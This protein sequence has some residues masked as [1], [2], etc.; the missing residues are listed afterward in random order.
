MR[1]AV[2]FRD[3]TDAAMKLAASLSAYKGKQP[4]ILAIPRGAVPMGRILAD[5]LE[6]ELDV[7]LV[8]KLGAPF[9][10]EYAIGAIDESG[11]VHIGEHALAAGES[12]PTRYEPGGRLDIPLR[13]EPGR[14]QGRWQGG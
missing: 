11:W 10:A 6:G 8:R 9:N 2:L 3:R 7:V 14:V 12:C 1:Q 13:N 4:L 5:A